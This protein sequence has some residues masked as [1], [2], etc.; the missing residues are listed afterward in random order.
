MSDI[1]GLGTPRR[2]FFT[3]VGKQN[4]GRSVHMV[5]RHPH[6]DR[7]GG[8]TTPVHLTRTACEETWAVG[9][10]TLTADLVTCPRCDEWVFANVDKF[11]DGIYVRILD[12]GKPL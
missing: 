8:H 6:T 2:D 11:V 12:G 1:C 7:I 5:R 10:I 3:V 4:D 9:H